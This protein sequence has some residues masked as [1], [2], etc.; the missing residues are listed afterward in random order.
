MS[1]TIDLKVIP[2]AKHNKIILDKSGRLVFYIK[3]PAQ[4][5]KANEELIKILGLKLRIPK[6]NISIISGHKTRFKRILLD[7]TNL[8]ID[9]LLNELNLYPFDVNMK[10][11]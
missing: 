4:D 5:N 6:S 9:T 10:I 8:T 11:Y 7:Q 2:G 3:S 1:L